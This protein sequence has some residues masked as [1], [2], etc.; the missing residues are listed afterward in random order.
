MPNY[1]TRKK[2]IDKILKRR[3][4]IRNTEEIVKI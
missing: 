3:E 1:E 4:E 2:M